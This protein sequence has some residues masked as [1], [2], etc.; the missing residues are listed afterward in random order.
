M[1]L[2]YLFG[3]G[4]GAGGV[5]ARALA[6]GEPVALRGFGKWEVVRCRERQVRNPNNDG[7]WLT[8]PARGELR[9]HPFKALRELV[10][11][12]RSVTHS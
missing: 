10:K 2:E 11:R 9:F 7:T 4:D 1:F 5:I 3:D 8:I 12:P 6:D